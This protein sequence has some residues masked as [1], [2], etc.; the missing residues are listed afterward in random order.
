VGNDLEEGSC[1]L[2]H[3]TGQDM[4]QVPFEYKSGSPLCD[5]VGEVLNSTFVSKGGHWQWHMKISV[6]HCCHMLLI[7]TNMKSRIGL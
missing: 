1:G 4:N 3:G 5:V 2:F 6:R 7:E